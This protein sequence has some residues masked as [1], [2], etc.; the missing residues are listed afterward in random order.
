VQ[1]GGLRPSLPHSSTCSAS[2]HRRRDP[3]H[4]STQWLGHL[5]WYLSSLPPQSL[6]LKLDC[7]KFEWSSWAFLVCYG[8]SWYF[9]KT[10]D[11]CEWWPSSSIYLLYSIT[12]LNSILRVAVWLVVFSKLIFSPIIKKVSIIYQCIFDDISHY[13]MPTKQ[14]HLKPTMK[15]CN[16]IILVI[17]TTK[18]WLFPLPPR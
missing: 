7:S 18:K 2:Q 14:D 17:S 10:L 9:L 6:L 3:N 12:D 13:K 11:G 1:T 8:T 4:L 15:I 16:T 5:R